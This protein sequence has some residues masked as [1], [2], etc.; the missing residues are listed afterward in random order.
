[1]TA[2]LT[3]PTTPTRA[4]QSRGPS[5][6]RWI[7][8]HAVFTKGRWY[9]QPFVLQAWERSVIAAL[10]EVREDGRRRYRRAL[11]GIP[12]KNGKSELAAALACYA[13]IGDRE[14]QPEV[15]VAA[16][17]DDQADLVFGAAKT[18]CE[19]SPTLS[20]MTQTFARQIVIPSTGGTITRI[21]TRAKTK[22][23][24]N[25]SMAIF[26]EYH[27]FDNESGEALYN[28][29]SNGVGARLEP[30]VLCI[31]TAGYD[32]DTPCGRMYS[33]GLKVRSGETQDD[34]FLFRWYGAPPDAD[35][36]EPTVWEQ[37][38]PSYGVTVLP[39]FYEDQVQS[40]PEGVFRRYFLNQWT[41]VESLWLP[42]GAWE[43]CADSTEMQA[44]AATFVGWDAARTRDTT[45]VVWGQRV[46]DRVVVRS[47]IWERPINPA[48][49]RT[50]E[51]W[52]TP[53]AAIMEHIRKLA[54]QYEVRAIGYD[55]WG[56][57]ESVQQL[58]VE[59]LPMEE[60]PQTNARMIP[61]TEYLYEL[62]MD[63]VIAHDGDPTFARHMR[64]IVARDVSGGVRMD[65][66]RARKPMDAGIAT[67]IVAYLLQNNPTED[68]ASITILDWS[69]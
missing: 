16:N 6:C 52:V 38:N 10:Y 31:T 54:T 11:I 53:V 8:Q 35:Y 56:I 30:L 36:R 15:Y 28:T 17:S 20:R 50:I 29:V 32:L 59:G 33:H 58:T 63:G 22:D 44:G 12:K 46:G 3:R 65:K 66:G 2:T 61:A 39:E 4:I 49:G 45:A 57:K 1:M 24:L 67:A 21:A 14:P 51:E 64:N 41:E 68:A 48:T 5:V 9:G 7:E 19:Q 26:D 47:R 62:I 25:V 34:A 55:P 60:V 13:A 27:E 42:A 43:A 18:M 69:P 37:A 23:G 40:K